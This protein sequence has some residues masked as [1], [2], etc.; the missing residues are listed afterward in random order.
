MGK[1]P[2]VNKSGGTAPGEKVLRGKWGKGLG[3]GGSAQ[4]RGEV[5]LELISIEVEEDQLSAKGRV[6][7]VLNPLFSQYG[8]GADSPVKSK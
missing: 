1:G 7:S 5:V 8:G 4:G 3:R 6:R 2:I